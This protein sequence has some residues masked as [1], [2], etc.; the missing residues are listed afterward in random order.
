MER[1]DISYSVL[2]LA[3]L[4]AVYQLTNTVSKSQNDSTK[5][6]KDFKNKKKGKC[7]L[8]KYPRREKNALQN[9]LEVSEDIN[10]KES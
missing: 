8:K 9:V 10:S 4:L 6:E 2:W 1:T 5:A 7:L 3:M